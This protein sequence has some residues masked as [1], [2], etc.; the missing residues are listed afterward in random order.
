MP[1]CGY[2][3]IDIMLTNITSFAFT[4][5]VTAVSCRVVDITQLDLCA[6]WP[7]AFVGLL[8]ANRGFSFHC[9]P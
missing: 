9:S 3:G 1:R 4:N 5:D 6:Y 7:Y 8:F 2:S